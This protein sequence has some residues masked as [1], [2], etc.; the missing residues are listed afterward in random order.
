VPPGPPAPDGDLVALGDEQTVRH[1]HLL[2]G[3]GL[4]RKLSGAEHRVHHR[5][6]SVQAETLGNEEILHE[7]EENRR[8]VGQAGSFDDDSREGRQFAAQAPHEEIA[9]RPGQIAADGTAQTAGFEENE[10]LVD[11]STRR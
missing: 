11:V 6:H 7:R 8:R 3:F 5:D 10:V 1:R 2:D 9:E 4:A